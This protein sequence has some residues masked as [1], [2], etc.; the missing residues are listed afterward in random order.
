MNAWADTMTA[1]IKARQQARQRQVRER[2][3]SEGGKVSK[4]SRSGTK[5]KNKFQSTVQH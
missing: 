1:R 3:E 5:S 4:V 2:A